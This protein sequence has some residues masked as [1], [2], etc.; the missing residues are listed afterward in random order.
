MKFAKVIYEKLIYASS[1]EMD[2][3]NVS[4]TAVLAWGT[5]VSLYSYVYFN[6]LYS[7]SFS[8]HTYLL[9]IQTLTY[10]STLTHA[11]THTHIYTETHSHIHTHTHKYK[12]IGVH[13]QSHI[14][15]HTHIMNVSRMST[16][17]GYELNYCCIA[18]F[19]V[20]CIGRNDLCLC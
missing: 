3:S 10:S 12:H 18:C 14:R 6:C 19:F 13:K 1:N 8:Y 15:A 16:S 7:C 4:R 9:L 2:F 17:N 5:L 11:H 20:W